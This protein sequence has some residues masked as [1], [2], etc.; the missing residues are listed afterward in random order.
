MSID[1]GN[2][3]TI[4]MRSLLDAKTAKKFGIAKTSQGTTKWGISVYLDKEKHLLTVAFALIINCH[5]HTT[6]VK[7]TLKIS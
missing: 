5:R 3:I 6:F 1:F 2:Y 7:L 4:Q